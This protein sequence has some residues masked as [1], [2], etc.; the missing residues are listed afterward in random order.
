[1]HI[2]FDNLQDWVSDA[3]LELISRF[4]VLFAF[5]IP[6]RDYSS[7]VPPFCGGLSLLFTLFCMGKL[8]VLEGTNLA[9]L[10]GP[11]P[12]GSEG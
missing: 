6:V 11:G 5:F 8:T 1:M 10:L 4:G 2:S 3:L 7:E 12:A 9:R